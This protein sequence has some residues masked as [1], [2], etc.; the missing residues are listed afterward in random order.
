MSDFRNTDVKKP[1][2]EIHIFDILI[3]PSFINKLKYTVYSE[4]LSASCSSDRQNYLKMIHRTGS[5]TDVQLGIHV[6]Q[7]GARFRLPGHDCV[8]EIR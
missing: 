4:Y 2:W 7:N 8:T 1:G 3:G 5:A 6:R